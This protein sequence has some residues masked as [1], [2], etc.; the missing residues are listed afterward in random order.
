MVAANGYVEANGYVAAN[1]GVAAKGYVATSGY[2]EANG[3]RAYKPT[4]RKT[5]RPI[6]IPYRPK[7]GGGRFARRP[8]AVGLFVLIDIGL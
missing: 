4:D 3:Y 8:P 2:V 6:S 7:G 1:G 5:Y